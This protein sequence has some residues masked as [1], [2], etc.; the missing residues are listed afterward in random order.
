MLEK[1]YAHTSNVVNA[2]E[3]MKPTG[4]GKTRKIGAVCWTEYI[5]RYYLLDSK[6]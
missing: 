3:L 1:H 2:D 5:V 6:H 4:G